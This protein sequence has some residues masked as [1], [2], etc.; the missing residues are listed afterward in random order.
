MRL[1]RAV[2]LTALLITGCTSGDPI[3]VEGTLVDGVGQPVP[4]VTVLLDS[5][6]NGAKAPDQG[7]EQFEVQATTGPDG[8]FEFR[9]PPTDQLRRMAGPNAPA[10][11]FTIAAFD[12]VRRLTWSWNFARELEATDWTH[13]T[14]PVRLVPVGHGG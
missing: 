11:N 10:V 4:G 6:D 1:R 2:I 3:V 13:H 8:R 9:F 12:P 14:T 7:F 5:F